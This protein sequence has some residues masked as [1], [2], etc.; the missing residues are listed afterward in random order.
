MS[1]RRVSALTVVAGAIAFAVIAALR[2][3]WHPVPW[4]TEPIAASEVFTAAQIA[5]AERFATWA[6]AWSWSALAVSLLVAV[7]LARSAAAGGRLRALLDRCTD[8]AGLRAALATVVTMG[9][10]FL[11]GLPFTV[12]LWSLRRDVGLSTQTLGPMLLDALRW[13]L[14]ALVPTVI[15]VLGWRAIARRLPRAWPALGALIAGAFALLGSFVWPVLIE[16]MFNDFAPLPD[17]PLRTQ[18]LSVAD[19]EGVPLDDVLVA[20]ASRRTTALN[21]YVSGYGSTRRVVLYDTLVESEPEPVVVSVAAHELAH[22]RYD[23][24]LTGS[25]LAAAG[26]VAGVGGLGL[27]FSLGGARRRWGAPGSGGSVVLVLAL[28]T[29][30]TVLTAPLSNGISRLIETRADVVAIESTG[31][32]RAAEQVERDL[33]LR[34]VADPT[35]PAWSQWMFGSHP[36]TMERI[37]IARGAPTG[38]AAQGR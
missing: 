12:A 10:A 11:V 33:A 14:I 26:A 6:R 21:A 18:I 2:V 19:R 4:P 24:P 9:A 35:P 8:R 25:L 32:S 23:D 7:V 17:G 20:D 29:W 30:A 13:Q 22:A 27:I 5:R 28:A 37:A 34:N 1:L 16:P 38:N 3:P 31:D 15:A 36:T